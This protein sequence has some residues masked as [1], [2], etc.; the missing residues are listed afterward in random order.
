MNADLD[1]QLESGPTP[2]LMSLYHYDTCF[3]CGMV[4]SKI[5]QLGLDIE[6]RNIMRDAKHRAGLQA[7]GGRTTVPCL[8]IDHPDGHVEWM[9]ES[10]DICHYLDSLYGGA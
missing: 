3:F 10:R 4:R 5:D 9:Y 2:D 7:G 8:R 6:L 1:K